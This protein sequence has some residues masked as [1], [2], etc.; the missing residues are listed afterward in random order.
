MLTESLPIFEQ[1]EP[2]DREQI[3]YF[4]SEALRQIE[5][6]DETKFIDTQIN[7]IR[8]SGKKGEQDYNLHELLEKLDSA[9]DLEEK[10]KL[11]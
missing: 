1:Y 3:Y 8:N 9:F 4:Y 11:S 6:L 7:D 10:N 2:E 5:P